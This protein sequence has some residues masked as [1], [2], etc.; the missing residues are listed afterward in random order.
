[1]SKFDFNVLFEIL[2]DLAIIAVVAGAGLVL[3][4]LAGYGVC[5]LIGGIG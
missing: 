2:R 4:T 3:G 5:V 1:M